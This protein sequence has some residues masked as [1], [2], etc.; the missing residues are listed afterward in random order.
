MIPRLRLLI[1]SLTCSLLALV[2]LRGEV[3]KPQEVAP[4]VWFHEGDLV[5]KGQCNNGWIIFND[6]VL[7]I[8]ANWPSAAKEILAK[9]R[10]I[11]DKPVR[12]ALDS[13]HHGDH[14][15]GNEVWRAQGATIVA[16]EG[17]IQEMQTYEPGLYGKGPGRWE[18]EA[19]KRKDVAESKLA[20]PTLLFPDAMIFD[21][22]Q[23]RVELI[24]FGI[25]HT[26]GDAFAWLP[27]EGILFSGDACV[28]GPYNYMG[29]GHTGQWIQTL[30]SVRALEPKIIC[31]GHGLIGGPEILDHQIEYIRS[32][33][34]EVRALVQDGKD[35][36]SIRAM[37]P[38]IKEKIQL[39]DRIA[40]YVGSFFEAQIEK[41]VLELQE[42]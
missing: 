25:A 31:P 40:N 5:R 21:D 23:Q 32:L 33:R 16:H 26:H 41:M 28:N 14:A 17:V 42:P 9:I 2:S 34:N 39:N 29:D 19:A 8:D 35:L 18:E 24:H 7:V 15:Y 13:H 27:K 1:G 36:E 10:Q 12:F 3:G 38:V 30:E 4:G 20:P 22:G 6:Y 11:T 37:S